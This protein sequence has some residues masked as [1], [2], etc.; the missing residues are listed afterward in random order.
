MAMKDIPDAL[1]LKAYDE[2]RDI[3]ESREKRERTGNGYTYPYDLLMQW[4][5]QPFKV[6][7]KCMQ[8]AESRGL[9]DCGVSLRTGWITD[10]GKQIFNPCKEGE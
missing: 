6:C 4:T 2:Y 8:R 7:Y 3:P 5:G 10:K 1:V 9:V